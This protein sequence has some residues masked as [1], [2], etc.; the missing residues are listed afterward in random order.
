MPLFQ[1]RTTI[2]LSAP[3]A[4]WR[5]RQPSKLWVVSSN[6]ARGAQIKVKGG[7]YEHYESLYQ[8]FSRKAIG[9]VSVEKDRQFANFVL[10]SGRTGGIRQIKFPIL[11]M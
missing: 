4:Q 8:V 6:L 3:V 7:I 1:G 9:R 11:K 10:L 5:E 2:G